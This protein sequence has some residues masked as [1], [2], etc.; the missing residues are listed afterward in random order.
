MKLAQA[1]SRI[2][3][4][5]TTAITDRATELRAAGKDVGL[6]FVP[7]LTPMIRGIHS[8]LY[9]TVVDRSVDLQTPPSAGQGQLRD[10]TRS[11]V[12]LEGPEDVRTVDI[13][14]V[15]DRR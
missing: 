7:H 5:R 14:E 3:P 9:A 8:T 4:S 11:D 1:L 2:A 12:V 10:G 15:V 13:A 6:T